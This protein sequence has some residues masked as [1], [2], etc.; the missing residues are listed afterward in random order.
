MFSFTLIVPT[1]NAG[2]RWKEWFV[3][4]QKQTLQPSELIVIDSSSID[5]TREIAFE[6][7]CK[8]IKIPSSEFNHGGTRNRALSQASDSE[9]IV[10]LT[11]D[12]IF[13]NEDALANMIEVFQDPDVAAVCGRQIPHLDANPLAVHARNFN[14]GSTSQIKSK[15]DIKNF[16]IKTVFM[17][18]SFAAYRRSVF[19][20]LG[21]FPE[22]TILAEDMFM[23][24]K[25][26]QAGY[27]VAY[28]GTAV[29]RHSHNYSP[30]EEF[31]RYF[32]TGVFH[33]CNPWIQQD[34]GGAGGEGSR[35]VKSEICFL[36][37][38]APLWIPRA[39]LTTFAKLLGYK[40]GKR[41]QSLPLPLCR[42]L[43]MYKSYWN[44]FKRSESKEIR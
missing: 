12:A 42:F 10:F 23:A 44:N 21:G 19:E 25:M 37:K 43:S 4:L 32:D 29:V 28:C 38:K 22:H 18:N 20:K 8:L 7:D 40:L 39:L 30:R 24:A 9:L 14:Y 1:Y 17:S 27:K 36:L 41:W 15:S 31:Q 5:N 6:F 3:A 35:F 16:G 2:E 33:A 26:I 13:D 11:Q 34:F